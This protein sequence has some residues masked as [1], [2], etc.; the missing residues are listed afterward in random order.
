M[1]KRN[2]KEI[3][4]AQNFLVNR[5][6]VRDLVAASSIRAEDTVYE[7]GAG[8]GI[9]TAEL[10]RAARRVVALE[11]DPALA[12]ELRARFRDRPQVEILERDFLEYR[13][14][15]PRYKIFANIPFN[16][17]ADIVRKILGDIPG[18]QEAYLVVQ[19][20]AAEKFCGRPRET[21][22]SLL[23]KPFFR[24]E[25]LRALRRTDF[26]PVPGVDSVLLRIG[27]RPAPLI[28]RREAAQYRGFIHHAFGVCKKSAR[29]IL[30]PVLSF[31][32]WKRLSRDLRI[33]YD[34]VPSEISF[35]QWL[36]LFEFCNREG[37][38]SALCRFRK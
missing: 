13:I 36:G 22:F 18:P 28:P 23:A 26:S 10:A 16:R 1:A 11:I 29:L 3:A 33:P 38:G 9:L 14:A 12:R 35:D 24:M 37:A 25:I 4:W 34:A 27:R 30:N 21:R 5:R 15:L 31:R 2:R 19:R 6:L 8:G 17:T 7:I 32:R 20:E